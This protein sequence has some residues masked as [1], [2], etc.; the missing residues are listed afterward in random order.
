MLFKI[1][2]KKQLGPEDIELSFSQ[3]K[4]KTNPEI[5][6]IIKDEWR[7]LVADYESKNI[8]TWNGKIKCLNSFEFKNQKLKLDLGETT[9]R[10]LAGTHAPENN[11]CE[12]FGKEYSA[13][14]MHVQG[15]VI[16][17]DNYLVFGNRRSNNKI[18]I[19]G[20][21]LDKDWPIQKS[22][23]LF[24]A[25]NGELKEELGI[26]Q[27]HIKNTKLI[28]LVKTIKGKYA[29]C[30]LVN[31][32]IAKKQVQ[33]VFYKKGNDEHDELVFCKNN[34]KAIRDFYN[35]YKNKIGNSVE[36]HLTNL[37]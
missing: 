2:V 18:S 10:E 34:K 26:K 22:C 12:R 6:K 24:K 11:V 23:D 27:I 37:C 9:F 5:E 16:T 21:V 31:L 32:L 29:L 28:A 8:K 33:K 3:C 25:I 17:K 13:R 19:L 15:A 36:M 30:F 1:L 7:Q 14:G 20:G 4:R 35:K